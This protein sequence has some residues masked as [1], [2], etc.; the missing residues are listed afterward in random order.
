[1]T[2][3]RQHGVAGAV[4]IARDNPTRERLNHAARQRRKDDGSLPVRGVVVGGREFAAGDRII[5]RRNDRHADID[6]GTLATVL[7]I[8]D[9]A[10]R[11][12]IETDRGHQQRELDL[13]YV[14]RHVEHAYALTGHGA[15]GATVD[16]AAVI[17]RPHEF[18]REW[19]YTALS[20]ARRSTRLHVIS[21]ADAR[22]RERQGY[23]PEAAGRAPAET[24]AALLRTMSHSETD[25]LP[26]STTIT[27]SY[28][29]SGIAHQ[30]RVSPHREPTSSRRAPQAPLRSFPA[31]Q[32]SGRRA[33]PAT[34]AS[35]SPNDNRD[36]DLWAADRART[37]P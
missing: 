33:R 27:L 23:A 22:D 21:Q 36:F 12:I 28:R 16:W 15:Q 10:H 31:P 14:H 19:A 6:N 32:D 3:Q 37:S 4:M 18:T 17:G 1:M 34:A 30:S 2:A 29:R 8:D 7:G 13:A 11:M 26:S 9:R 35:A 20:R 24:V 25:P 5:A